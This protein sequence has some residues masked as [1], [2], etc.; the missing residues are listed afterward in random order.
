MTNFTPRAATD[1]EADAAHL[2]DLA[3]M[4]G[5]GLPELTWQQMAGPG[6]TVDDVGRRR[7]RRGEGA[8]SWRNA[9]LFEADGKVAGG[10][11]GYPLPEEPVEIGPDFPAPFVPLQELENLVGGSWYVNILATYPNWR[12]RGV[13]T[14]MLEHAATIAREAGASGLSIIVFSANP[15]ALRLYR[16]VGFSEV[17]RRRLSIDGWRHDGCDAI[18]LVKDR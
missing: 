2:A 8:F 17:A 3:R 6:E 5:D 9:T 15:G 10:L 7:A 16:R 12:G 14:K 13:G 1:S 18:L 11:L 4:A